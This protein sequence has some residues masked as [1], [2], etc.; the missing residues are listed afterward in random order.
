MNVD[1]RPFTRNCGAFHA[2]FV[3]GRSPWDGV[4]QGRYEAYHG[5]RF[6]SDALDAS[7]ACATAYCSD[8]KLPDSAIDVM[9]EAAA[10]RRMQL[11][12][13]AGAAAAAAPH[14]A[15]VSSERGHTHSPEIAEPVVANAQ[16]WH[17]LMNADVVD[18]DNQL[19]FE[20]RVAESQRLAHEMRHMAGATTSAVAQRAPAANPASDDPADCG[21]CAKS[22]AL[23]QS[24]HSTA[25]PSGRPSGPYRMP[26]ICPHCGYAVTDAPSATLLCPDCFTLFLNIS[27]DKLMLGTSAVPMHIR[28]GTAAPA[29]GILRTGCAGPQI[30]STH[31][32]AAQAA[33]QSVPCGVPGSGSVADPVAAQAAL[34]A[35]SA[36]GAQRHASG[37]DAADACAASAQVWVEREHVLEV[38][39]AQSGV[40]H[41]LLAADAAWF[42][43]LGAKLE[44]EVWG[45]GQ[46]VTCASLAVAHSTLAPCSGTCRV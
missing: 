25:A 2:H 22:A 40:P 1:C 33:S 44:S 30:A 27:Q 7:V 12:P 11:P 21:S 13:S 29:G 37:A 19:Q 39:S 35:L 14:A 32:V 31:S 8:R 34:E 18:S 45:Q 15:A 9:D 4:T 41:G 3:D 36:P 24:Q 46:A 16:A 43:D 6:T 38:V 42:A 5:V 17:R 28:M 20:R 26:K 23:P 10:L